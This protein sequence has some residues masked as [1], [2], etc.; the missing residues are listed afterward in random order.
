MKK[1]LNT[2]MVK[3]LGFYFNTAAIVAPQKIAKKAFVLFCTPRKGKVIKGQNGFLEDAKDLILEVKKTKVQTYLWK[4]SGPTI[5]LMHGW[6]SN[7][8]RWRN[9]I[10]I[11]Q[12]N[13]YN[14]VA[15]DAP[16]HGNSTGQQFHVP[17]YTECAQEVINTY[18]PTHII[19]HSIGGMALI[20]NLYKHP[21]ENKDI[22]KVV[23]LGSPS[24]LSD[25]MR[26][27]KAILGLNNKLINLMEAHFIANFGFKFSDFS[28]SK[29]ANSITKSGL[30]IH[31]KLD[32]IAPYWSSQQ[33]HAN[34]KNSTLITTKGLGHSL[35]QDKVRL[36]ILD[37][38]ESNE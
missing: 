37:F 31:D 4:G 27:Y 1:L 33:V 17:L 24:E 28:S 15:M 38:L 10:P 6:E 16:A 5:L 32:A 8:Y 3:S 21:K 11:L 22:Q 12:N 18:R 35:H 34:W 36:S 19:G 26:Q 20:Y 2:I 13:N 29:F 7:T 30:L 25:F 9:L 23:T 14:V